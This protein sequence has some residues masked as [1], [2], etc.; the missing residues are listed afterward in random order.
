MD[1]HARGI[2]TFAEWLSLSDA[3]RRHET[4]RWNAYG[5]EGGEIVAAITEDVRAKYGKIPGVE[6]TG[7]G[8]YHGGSWVIA[9][10]HPFIFDRRLLP[11]S[12]LGISVHTSYGRELPP[13]FQDGKRR[14]SYVW[15]PPHYE[16]FVDRCADEIRQRL[17]RPDMSREEMLAALVRMPFEEFR[18][19]CRQSVREGRIAA[20]EKGGT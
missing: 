7:F 5:G 11:L 18:E 13:E 8:V 2:P 6:V 15:A 1:P 9:V 17:R 20:F 14:Y 19:H 4:E 3:E 12:H 10:T 16:D